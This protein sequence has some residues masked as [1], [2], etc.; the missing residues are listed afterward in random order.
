[1]PTTQRKHTLKKWLTF[2]STM[3]HAFIYKYSSFPCLC[4]SV[5]RRHEALMGLGSSL[6]YLHTKWQTHSFFTLRRSEMLM[7]YWVRNECKQPYRS[8]WTR[9]NDHTEILFEPSQVLLNQQTVASIIG[10]AIEDALLAF[11]DEWCMIPQEIQRWFRMF[12]L[13]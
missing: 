3:F 1:M 11:E 12:F 4:V 9:V 8:S 13:L 7:I 10:Y 2:S 5:L 6:L